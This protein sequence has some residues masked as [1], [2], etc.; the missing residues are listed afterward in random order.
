MTIWEFSKQVSYRLLAWA[1]LSV[2]G[3]LGL[4]WGKRPFWRGVG[5]QCVGWGLVDAVIALV[6]R[7]STRRKQR[8]A[9]TD[10][11]AAGDERRSLARLLWI[12]T[13][14]DVFYVLGGVWLL[15][16]RGEEASWRGHG[17]GVI[18]QGAFLFFFD[19]WH[20]LRLRRFHVN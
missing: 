1:G 11:A 5:V 10:P 8:A 14:L 12:N 17:W 15:R 18:V 9:E 19:L 4:I 16:K 2:F 3:G 20:A 7:R 13:G 6:G